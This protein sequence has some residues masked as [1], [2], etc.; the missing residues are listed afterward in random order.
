MKNDVVKITV[1]ST[2]QESGRVT[3]PKEVI[4]I[5]ASKLDISVPEFLRTHL[6]AWKYEEGELRGKFVNFDRVKIWE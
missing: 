4:K 3:I 2:D 1:A 5:E 6:F